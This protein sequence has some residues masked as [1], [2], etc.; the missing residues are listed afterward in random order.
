MLPWF[1]Q[2]NLELTGRYTWKIG[3][4]VKVCAAATDF[5]TVVKLGCD[6][7]T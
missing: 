5:R 1:S 2:R 6:D 4:D 7:P 3:S